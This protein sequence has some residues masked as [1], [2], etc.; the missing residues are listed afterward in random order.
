MR[1]S[2]VYDDT[3]WAHN[4]TVNV[5]ADNA[6]ASQSVSQPVSMAIPKH[7]NNYFNSLTR[8]VSLLLFY[9]RLF[10]LLCLNVINI[11]PH[12]H[13]HKL[14][15]PRDDDIAGSYDFI[16]TSISS[17]HGHV[18]LL[19]PHVL[20]SHQHRYHDLCLSSLFNYFDDCKPYNG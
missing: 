2:K 13:C 16:A 17:T 3:L 19:A 20:T 8:S 4:W 10:A 18:K 7:A 12:L 9:C 11:H 1:S 6:P 15:A 5:T 14:L